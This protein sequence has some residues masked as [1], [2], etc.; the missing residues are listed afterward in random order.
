M[1]WFFVEGAHFSVCLSGLRQGVSLCSPK[2][3]Q[4]H[5]NPSASA[6]RVLGLKYG[7]HTELHVF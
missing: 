7:Q 5:R 4:N 6:S 1:H 2:L 3:A